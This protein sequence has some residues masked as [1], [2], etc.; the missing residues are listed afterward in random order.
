MITYLIGFLSLQPVDMDSAGQIHVLPLPR[1][2]SDW[3]TQSPVH[4]AQSATID[5]PSIL[6]ETIDAQYEGGWVT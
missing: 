3:R 2:D 1:F 4:K 5:A 6:T